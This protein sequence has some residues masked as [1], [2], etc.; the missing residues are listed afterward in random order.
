MRKP[1]VTKRR[2]R[3]GRS[4]P[5]P[6]P[7]DAGDGAEVALRLFGLEGRLSPLPADRDRNFRLTTTDGRDFVLKIFQAGE[8]PGVLECQDEVLE[9]LRAARLPWGFPRVRPTVAGA[10]AGVWDFGGA[11][12]FVRMAEWVPGTALAHLG[13]RPPGLET[14]LGRL[15][16]SMGRALAG[17]DHPAADR[18]FEWDL[19][20][21]GEVV[22]RYLE[23]VQD[24]GRRRLVGA[25]RELFR[26]RVEP[27]AEAL[28]CAVIHGDANDHNVLVD[29][30]RPDRV[31]GLVDFGDLVRS[32]RVAEPAVA[33]A[34]ALL[35]REDPLATIGRVTA[36]HH[37]ELPLGDEEWRALFPLT[38]IRLCVSVVQSARRG[39]ERPDDPYLRVSEAPAWRAL[40]RLA[41]IHPDEADEAVRRAA[42]GS[43]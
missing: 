25:F 24:E 14:D 36:G 13:R 9:R 6:P 10:R 16:G 5:G 42:G 40:E 12:Y 26:A 32:W 27:V 19:R 31:A 18:V 33:A 34:Y 1:H 22:D 17:Y 3:G 4:D 35:D 11:P 28:P 15:T 38:A 23:H 21:A 37:G 2:P 39:P 43:G 30:T 8:D 20:R 41:R 7:F 29:P